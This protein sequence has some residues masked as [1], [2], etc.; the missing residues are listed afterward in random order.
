[1]STNTQNLHISNYPRKI[2]ITQE[3][4]SVLLPYY[5]IIM[6]TNTKEICNEKTMQTLAFFLIE[7]SYDF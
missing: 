6:F 7:H 4:Y 1:M 2:Q 5:V 3:L